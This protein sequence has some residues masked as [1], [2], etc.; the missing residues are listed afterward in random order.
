MKIILNLFRSTL[1]AFTL[2]LAGLSVVILWQG[3]S[4][5]GGEDYV[6]FSA[7]GMGMLVIGVGAFCFKKIQFG[8]WLR[9]IFTCIL[10]LGS[11]LLLS[12]YIEN[13]GQWHDLVG[14]AYLLFLGSA[15]AWH[16]F[17][18]DQNHEAQTK[19]VTAFITFTFIYIA[20]G[21]IREHTMARLVFVALS[22][23]LMFYI[24]R[25]LTRKK[26]ALL[27]T[28][29]YEA[30]RKRLVPSLIPHDA[31]LEAYTYFYSEDWEALDEALS[32]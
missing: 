26:R 29:Q 9:L 17:S 32:K 23:T 11:A 3:I 1:G 21:M 25:R 4:M 30:L 22:A 12:R 7:I 28:G 13:R 19:W 14:V 16:T 2:G 24:S 31:V 20:F 10:F 15:Q 18:K 6:T 8:Q 5:D 27:F